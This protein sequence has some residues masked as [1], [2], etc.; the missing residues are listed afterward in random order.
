MTDPV[1]G[2]TKSSTNRRDRC[3]RRRRDTHQAADF[4][5]PCDNGI[6]ALPR[7]SD[8]QRTRRVAFRGNLRRLSNLA[9]PRLQYHRAARAAAGLLLGAGG[10]LTT[11]AHTINPPGGDFISEFLSPISR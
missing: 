2:G 6:T 11:I 5:T 7:D 3:P 8:D 10:A 4:P 1:V 9:R